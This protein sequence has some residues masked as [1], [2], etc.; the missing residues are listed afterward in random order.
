MASQEPRSQSNQEHVGSACTS[1]LRKYKAFCSFGRAEIKCLSQV[2]RNHSNFTQYI[3]FYYAEEM[4]RDAP[5]QG[6]EI[7]Y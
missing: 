3:S 4:H 5:G 7:G 2:V 1:S 6:A